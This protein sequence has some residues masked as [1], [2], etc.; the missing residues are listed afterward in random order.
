EPFLEELVGREDLP[1]E[2]GGKED[3]GDQQP[4]EHVAEHELQERPVAAVGVAGRA[5]ERQ[6][7]RLRGHDAGGDRPP[8]DGA[9][10]EEVVLHRAAPP[11]E[12]GAEGSDARDV[13]D[14]HDRR[15]GGELHLRAVSLA[16]MTWSAELMRVI[17]RLR[18]WLARASSAG[19]TSARVSRCSLSSSTLRLLRSLAWKPLRA[20]R[21]GR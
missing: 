19:G 4:S 21:L 6:G 2:V 17:L 8:G 10:G 14:E 7:A 9:P 15:R 5:D 13:G 20:F 3:G 12:P 18:A 1:A 16:W 11:P